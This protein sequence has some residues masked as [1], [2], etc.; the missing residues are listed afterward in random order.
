MVLGAEGY[1]DWAAGEGGMDVFVLSG[2]GSPTVH[3]GML[4]WLR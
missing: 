4:G 3:D 1:V 2:F